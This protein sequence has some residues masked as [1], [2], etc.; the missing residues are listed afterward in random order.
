[1]AKDILSSFIF[2]IAFSTQLSNDVIATLY[3]HSSMLNWPAMNTQVLFP[4]PECVVLQPS[5]CSG[6]GLQH[7]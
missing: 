4:K 2:G 1:M 5:P 7:I 3:C 6:M